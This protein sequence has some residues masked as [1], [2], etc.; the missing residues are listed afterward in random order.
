MIVFDLSCPSGHR[1]EGWFKSS[2]EYTS[3]AARGLVS[4]PECGLT[5]VT[6]APMAPS[7]GAKGN[8]QVAGLEKLDAPRGQRKAPITN[9]KLPPEV[10]KAMRELPEIQAKALKDSKYVGDSFAEK[11]RAMHYGEQDAQNIH[12]EATLNEAKELLDE[13]IAVSPLP[14]PVAPPD[15]LN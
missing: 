13:G 8:R 4:C 9:G 6:K 7:V 11:S 5:G 1:F 2:E 12:G 15:D 10:G 14:F 3:Q